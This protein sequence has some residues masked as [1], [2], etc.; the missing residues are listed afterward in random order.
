MV[1]GSFAT[2]MVFRVGE[3]ERGRVGR[4]RTVRVRGGGV[5]MN[6]VGGVRDW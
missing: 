6:A 5:A 3:A 4:R 1:V 2:V